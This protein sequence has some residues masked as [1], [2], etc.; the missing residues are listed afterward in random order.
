MKPKGKAS[1]QKG[2]KSLTSPLD[3]SNQESTKEHCDETTW[4]FGYFKIQLSPPQTTHLEIP[5]QPLNPFQQ[6]IQQI[7]TCIEQLQVNYSQLYEA[8]KKTQD[9]ITHL[10]KLHTWHQDDNITTFS[11]IEGQV[12]QLDTQNSKYM[13]LFS[14]MMAANKEIG[15]T[16]AALA[17][18]QERAV[19]EQ[20]QM[21]A[22]Q[23]QMATE[24]KQM[25]F[26]RKK[27][28]AEQEQMIAEQ[29][30][31]ASKL[32]QIAAEQKQMAVEQKQMAAEQKKMATEQGQMAVER[33]QMA[34]DPPMATAT[35]PD[36]PASF[37]IGGLHNLRRLHQ[38]DKSDPVDLVS[39]LLA[40]LSLYHLM[41]K[42]TIADKDAKSSG[43]RMAA[44]AMIVGMR[45]A[46]HKRKA[47]ITIKRYLAEQR[48]RFNK[49]PGVT[50]ADCFPKEALKKAK[51]LGNL[52][53]AKKKEGNIFRFRVI[54]KDGQAILQISQRGK[55]YEDSQHSE[56]DLYA[57]Y[58]NGRHSSILQQQHKAAGDIHVIH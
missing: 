52:A 28:A 13:Q 24:Q 35:S 58:D 19:P 30:Q 31:M 44:R 17:R 7:A 49:M 15:D 57:F 55:P 53:T 40:H 6:T 29:K 50:V 18:I 11:K 41:E 26:E 51:A 27:M 5:D 48:K 14:T 39:D 47:I 9:I 34:I 2:T 38:D 37:F 36:Q 20:Q 12:K 42:M 43:D 23:K 1:K 33:E 56:K 3:G 54:N 22:E 46:Q 16:V 4:S 10:S 25:A 45:S 32:K 8:Q 21:A